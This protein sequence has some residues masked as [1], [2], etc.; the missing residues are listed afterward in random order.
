M[1]RPSCVVVRCSLWFVVVCN[2]VDY[3]CCRCV[4]FVV[5]CDCLLL[6]ISCVAVLLVVACYWLVFVVVVDARCRSL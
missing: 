3:Y 4:P 2:W 5:G 6:C 1:C